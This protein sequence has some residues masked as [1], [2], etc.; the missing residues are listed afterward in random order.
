MYHVCSTNNIK[1]GGCM[2]IPDIV[3]IRIHTL[4]NSHTDFAKKVTSVKIHRTCELSRS[5]N[6]NVILHNVALEIDT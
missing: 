6:F 1:I 3:F 4:E 2:E 5:R